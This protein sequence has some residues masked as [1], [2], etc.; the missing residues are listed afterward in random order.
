MNSPS[1]LAEKLLEAHVQYIKRTLT[2]EQLAH[3]INDEIKSLIVWLK[4]VPFDRVVIKAPLLTTITSVMEQFPFENDGV[5]DAWRG[6]FREY[7]SFQLRAQAHQD[8]CIEQVWSTEAQHQSVEKIV[9]LQRLRDDLVESILKSSIYAEL[10]SDLL[11]NGIKGFILEENLLSK[12]PGLSSIIKMGKWGMSRT[13]PNLDAFIEGAA[14]TF[15]INNIPNTISLSKKILENS[16]SPEYIR[17]LGIDFCEQVSAKNI[18]ELGRYFNEEDVDDFIKIIESE[19]QYYRKSEHFMAICAESI[20]FWLEKYGD[21]TVGDF[22]SSLGVDQVD[23]GMAIARYLAHWLGIAKE[24]GRLD[25]F[26]RRQLVGFYTSEEC[27]Q[28]L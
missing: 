23:S 13:M 11:Y 10:I 15:I 5:V 14:K 22:L 12:L 24:D 4:T 26:L 16:L 27:Q 2:T 9:D 28:V 19:W 1:A 18:A 17:R 20:D 7:L 3:H 6:L 25:E 8:H 21:V